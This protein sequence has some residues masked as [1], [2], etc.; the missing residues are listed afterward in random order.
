M[1]LP[2]ACICLALA[3]TLAAPLAEAQRTAGVGW[4]PPL[5]LDPSSTPSVESTN[6]PFAGA[7]TASSTWAWTSAAV[8]A[9][10]GGGRATLVGDRFSQTVGAQVG[11]GRG[12]ALGLQLPMMWLQSV[13]PVA[14]TASVTAG[15]AGDL[16]AVLRWA[17]MQAGSVV[18]A[19]IPRSNCRRGQPCSR[20]HGVGVSVDAAFTAP[21]AGGDLGGYGVP[22]GRLGVTTEYRSYRYAVALSAGYLAR[23]DAASHASDTSCA[24]AGVPC[25]AD[26]PLHDR[27]DVAVALRHPLSGLI[28]LFSFLGSG[29]TDFAGIVSYVLEQSIGVPYLTVV[30]SLDARAPGVAPIVEIGTG[31]QRRFGEV[32]LTLGYTRERA[33]GDAGSNRVLLGVQWQI[34]GDEDGDGV[35]D[36]DDRCIG[37]R[38]PAAFEGCP[39]PD[40]NLAIVIPPFVPR[41]AGAT[42]DVGPPE[43]CVVCRDAD[44][45]VH[46]AGVGSC[47]ADAGC[48]CDASV[49]PNWNDPTEGRPHVHE[50]R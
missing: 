7:V 47:D 45:R 33:F 29:P 44:A 48:G 25:L 1:S 35:R 46:D 12:V 18:D 11:L 26:T 39:D 41:D 32:L 24:I 27:V 50:V 13:E 9:D 31:T 34:G 22:T 8:R 5:S 2:A 38:G 42:P 17:P 49:S 16:R 6:V 37:V 28:A 21:T 30:A 14:A 10:V 43:R 40:P 36:A 19:S 4:I 20:R 3:L 23:F 15:G